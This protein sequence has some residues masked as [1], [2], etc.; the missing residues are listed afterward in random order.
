VT[1]NKHKQKFETLSLRCI[2]QELEAEG[3]EIE[4]ML[5]GYI[6]FLKKEQARSQRT[7]RESRRSG[8]NRNIRHRAVR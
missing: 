7:W 8:R 5:N 3:E 6:A 2:Y 1:P 4:K